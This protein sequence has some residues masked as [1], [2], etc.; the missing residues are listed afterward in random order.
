MSRNIRKCAHMRARLWNRRS[1]LSAISWPFFLVNGLVTLGF[2]PSLVVGPVQPAKSGYR[3]VITF[4]KYLRHREC[5]LGFPSI[6]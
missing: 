3:S 2:T 4:C 5:V 1:L 6:Q